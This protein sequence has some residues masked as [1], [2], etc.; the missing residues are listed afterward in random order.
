VVVVW[1]L[2]ACSAASS[3]SV[4]GAGSLHWSGFLSSTIT[5]QMYAISAMTGTRIDQARIDQL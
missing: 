4:V 2:A 1:R 3:S 5:R